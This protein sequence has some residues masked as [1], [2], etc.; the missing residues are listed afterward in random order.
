MIDA[1]FTSNDTAFSIGLELLELSGNCLRSFAVR[2][3]R[4]LSQAELI[5]P[6]KS[7]GRTSSVSL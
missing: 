7:L 3:Y 1:G 4:I 2:A 5:S 6:R